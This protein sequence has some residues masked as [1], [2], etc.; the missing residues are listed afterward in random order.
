MKFYHIDK[1][2]HSKK[3]FNHGNP[4]CS[5]VFHGKKLPLLL[6][7]CSR[8][9]KQYSQALS[10]SS[11]SPLF[12]PWG[13]DGNNFEKLKVDKLLLCFPLFDVCWAWSLVPGS[14]GSHEKLKGV[15]G[16]ESL[17]LDNDW[18]SVGI[19]RDWPGIGDWLSNW[20][21]ESCG[22]DRDKGIIKPVDDCESTEILSRLDWLWF[23]AFWEGELER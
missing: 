8:S 21:S 14:S 6:S 23:K 5:L 7:L 20:L 2:K 11:C 3:E 9:L 17:P 18:S 1:I 4:V 13:L 16:L 19:V 22:E 10:F 12:T 15:W